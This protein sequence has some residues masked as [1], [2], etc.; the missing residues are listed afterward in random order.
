[1]LKE[2]KVLWQLKQALLVCSNPGY[3]PL[4]HWVHRQ[5]QQRLLSPEK[6]AS[7]WQSRPRPSIKKYFISKNLEK[8]EK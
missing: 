3:G 2:Q 1:M 5:R 4:N 6:L 8:I 7:L